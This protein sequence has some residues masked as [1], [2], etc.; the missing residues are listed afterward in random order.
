M[1]ESSPRPENLE[2]LAALLDAL[3]DMKQFD[4]ENEKQSEIVAE[5]LAHIAESADK[6]QNL[7]ARFKAP[8]LTEDQR[9]DL[10]WEIGEELAHMDDHIHGMAYFD[11]QIEP[12]EEKRLDS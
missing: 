5:G 7:F 9:M 1:K 6:F 8:G 4:E 12:P 2:R 11:E 3:P 10:L